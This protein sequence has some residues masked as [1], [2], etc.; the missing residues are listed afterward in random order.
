MSDDS[1]IMVLMQTCDNLNKA[2]C[3]LA[4]VSGTHLLMIEKSVLLLD[5]QLKKLDERVRLL[6]LYKKDVEVSKF[7]YIN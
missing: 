6:E 1:A 7:D 5:E 3:E 2:L 4:Q